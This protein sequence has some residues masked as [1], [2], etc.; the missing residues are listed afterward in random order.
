MPRD[1]EEG[2]STR[3]RDPG[4]PEWVDEIWSYCTISS[5]ALSWFL[6]SIR[7]IIATG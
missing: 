3:F 6:R 4:K 7:I 1:I 5:N 2:L